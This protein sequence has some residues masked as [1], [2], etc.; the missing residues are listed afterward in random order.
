M[1]W[2]DVPTVEPVGRMEVPEAP[3]GDHPNCGALGAKGASLAGSWGQSR[4]EVAKLWWKGL[5]GLDRSK[6]EPK[7]KPGAAAAPRGWQG[8]FRGLQGPRLGEVLLNV[9]SRAL[10]WAEVSRE[11]TCPGNR[12]QTS[13]LLISGDPCP[14][15]IFP[16]RQPAPS[17]GPRHMPCVPTQPPRSAHTPDPTTQGGSLLEPWRLSGER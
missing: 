10:A 12:H 11:G 15:H 5:V 2:A 17:P 6:V 3:G 9:W 8:R 13:G 4:R 16:P 1:S 14:P 7:E